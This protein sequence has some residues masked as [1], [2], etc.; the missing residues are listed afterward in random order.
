M[1]LQVDGRPTPLRIRLAARWW[2][3]A[4][5]LLATPR[6]EDPCGLWITPCHSIHTFGMRYPIDA[7]F[8]RADGTILRVATGLAPW[9][10]AACRRARAT[11]ELRAG[12]AGELGLVPG[13]AIGL[14]PSPST[15]SPCAS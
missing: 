1:H 3:R 8:V 12:L 11:L 6:L 7:V 13:M 9:R 14:L 5:G 2:S 4:V 10:A 15:I